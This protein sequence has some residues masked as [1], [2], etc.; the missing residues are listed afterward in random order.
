MSAGQRVGTTTTAVLIVTD[1][2]M[3]DDCDDKDEEVKEETF[4]VKPWEPWPIKW[5]D[6]HGS[7]GC[8]SHEKARY[9]RSRSQDPED[10]QS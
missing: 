10:D 5:P 7:S 6:P 1:Q 8:I 2:V 9:K 3:V 4:V